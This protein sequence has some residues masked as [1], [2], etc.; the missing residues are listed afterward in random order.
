ML[1]RSEPPAETETPSDHQQDSP[2]RD[3]RDSEA[4]FYATPDTL[5]MLVLNFIFRSLSPNDVL[6]LLY[7]LFLA[8]L[9]DQNTL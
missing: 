1:L 9:L 3:R 8:L 7:A 6:L 4:G 5:N 2:L